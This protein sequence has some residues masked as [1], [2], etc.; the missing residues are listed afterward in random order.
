MFF[1]RLI[2]GIILVLAAI[3]FFVQGGYFLLFALAVLSLLGLYE[4]L[5][6]LQMEKSSYSVSLGN[7][8]QDGII[9]KTGMDRY[10]VKVSAETKLTNNFTTGFAGNY[11]TTSIDKA[12]TSGNGL[13]RTVYASPASYDLAGIP[14]HI[15]GNPYEQ[16]SFRGNFDNA[17]WALDNNKYTEDTNRFFGNVY[18]NYQTDFG[19]ANHKL[20]AKYM[21]GVD[22]YTTHYS[23]SYGYGS[24]TSRR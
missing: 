6:V 22:A 4:L 23:D 8:H 11:I 12:V 20:N 5:R 14:N 10:N 9:P 2:S 16:N 19:T 24:N 17:Y 3:F 21:L 15:D 13:L 1:T 18:A 7:T